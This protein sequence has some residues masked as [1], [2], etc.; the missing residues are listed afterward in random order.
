[1]ATA[2]RSPRNEA[3][4]HPGARG[5][6]DKARSPYGLP[7]I[8]YCTACPLRCN[9]FFCR[10]SGALLQEFDRIKSVSSYPEGAM[11]FMEDEVGRGVYIVCQGRVKLLATNSEGKRIII[12][13]AKPGDLLGLYAAIFA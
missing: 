13:I 2:L 1:M 12:K 8:E 10:V 7:L 6:H 3:Y 5:V 9:S 11:L 4:G